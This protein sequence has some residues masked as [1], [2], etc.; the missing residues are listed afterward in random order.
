MTTFGLFDEVV[1]MV[2]SLVEVVTV[3]TLVLLLGTRSNRDSNILATWLW[4][5][6]RLLNL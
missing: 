2:A 4:L 6:A 3:V 1:R 5:V